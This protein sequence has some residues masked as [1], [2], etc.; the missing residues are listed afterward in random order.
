MSD[1]ETE[2][3]EQCDFTAPKADDRLFDEYCG[4]M[5]CAKC[6]VDKRMKKQESGSNV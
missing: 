1:W 4:D 3:C 6:R 5:L 2:T